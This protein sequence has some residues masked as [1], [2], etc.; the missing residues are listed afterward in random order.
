M[1]DFD[2]LR[3]EYE[4]KFLICSYKYYVLNE[5]TGISDQEFDAICQHL[6]KEY[7]LTRQEFREIV[8][9]DDLKA[10][11]GAYIDF[12]DWVKEECKK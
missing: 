11:T 4:D 6:L 12:P 10:G 9:I 1:I 8:S 7:F 2:Q 5:P 3:D